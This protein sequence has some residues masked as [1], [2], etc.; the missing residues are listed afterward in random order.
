[1]KP[2]VVLGGGKSDTLNGGFSNVFELT[3]LWLEAEETFFNGTDPIVKVPFWIKESVFSSSAADMHLIFFKDDVDQIHVKLVGLY[4]KENN[5]N[6]PEYDGYLF[7]LEEDLVMSY[8]L[9]Y[10]GGSIVEVVADDEGFSLLNKND[11]GVCIVTAFLAEENGGG[12]WD[13]TLFPPNSP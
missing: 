7:I 2:K 9:D 11:D 1:M 8:V 5:D 12:I 6:T 4:E 3:P 10:V 13:F